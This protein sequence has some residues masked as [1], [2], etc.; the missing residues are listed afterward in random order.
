L[1]EVDET[2]AEPVL[3]LTKLGRTFVE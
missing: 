2:A 1:F 3:T